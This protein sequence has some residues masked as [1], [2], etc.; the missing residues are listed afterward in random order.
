M[1]GNKEESLRII[2]GNIQYQGRYNLAPKGI[3]SEMPMGEFS[4]NEVWK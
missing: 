4:A 1:G 2:S 3:N